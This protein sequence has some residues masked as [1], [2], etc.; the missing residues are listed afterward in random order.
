MKGVAGLLLTPMAPFV[1]VIEGLLAWGIPIESALRKAVAPKWHA[2]RVTLHRKTAKKK[3]DQFKEDTRFVFWV[4]LPPT[5][6]SMRIFYP[7]V[8]L[9]AITAVAAAK[10][11]GGNVGAY[12]RID[13]LSQR[14]LGLGRILGAMQRVSGFMSG[15][16]KENEHVFSLTVYGVGAGSGPAS[17]PPY[18]DFSEKSERMSSVF[19]KADLEKMGFNPTQPESL[20][21]YVAPQFPYYEPRLVPLQEAYMDDIDLEKDDKAR[22]RELYGLKKKGGGWWPF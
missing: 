21:W 12:P 10:P 16:L 19:K 18:K 2:M 7:F 3:A 22:L 1:P 8:D 6:P 9:P 15:I 20:F 4:K 14:T 5:A 13:K 17:S 11:V